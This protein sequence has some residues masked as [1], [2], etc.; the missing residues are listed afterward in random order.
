MVNGIVSFT[1]LSVFSLL[2]YRNA[3]DFC[4]L[5]L[6]TANLLY[7]VISSSNFPVESFCFLWRGSCHLQ[8]QF[9]FFF[10]KLDYFISFLLWLLW[11]QHPKLCWIV[12]VRVGTLV[13]FLTR[14]NAFNSSPL[15]II[16]VVRLSYIAFVILKYVPSKATPSSTLAWK[17]PW[18]EE[19]GRLQSMGSW[20]VGHD[21]AT[22]LSLF[23]FIHCRRKWQ[24]TAMFLPGESQG[25]R[26][27]VGCHLW[28]RTESDMTE[29]T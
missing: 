18:V 6:Y 7:L 12:V 17:I 4:E 14:G 3:R 25:W 9:Y 29:A 15:R 26:S 11:P 28:G 21:W 5:I 8:W 2:V 20:R 22:S 16:F 23:T 19:P 27:L 10:S 1:S 24:P 13:L